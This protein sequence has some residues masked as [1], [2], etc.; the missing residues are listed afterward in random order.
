MKARWRDRFVNSHIDGFEDLVK[1][2]TSKIGNVAATR[3]MIFR[4]DGFLGV[5]DKRY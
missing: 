4:S 3:Q 5:M 1:S 2:M